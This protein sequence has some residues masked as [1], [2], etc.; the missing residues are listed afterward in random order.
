MYVSVNQHVVEIEHSCTYKQSA[1]I[2]STA[3]PLN[4]TV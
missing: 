4:L 2:E 1:N 3:F